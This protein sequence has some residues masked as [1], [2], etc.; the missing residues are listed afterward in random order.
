MSE[1]NSKNKPGVKT[2]NPEYPDLTTDFTDPYNDNNQ[3]RGKDN[4]VGWYRSLGDGAVGRVD[5]GTTNTFPN[6]AKTGSNGQTLSAGVLGSAVYYEQS[7]YGAA[8]NYKAHYQSPFDEPGAAVPADQW[9]NS[10]NQQVTPY[11][12]TNMANGA[13]PFSGSKAEKNYFRIS[14]VS[15]WDQGASSDAADNTFTVAVWVRSNDYTHLEASQAYLPIITRVKENSSFSGTNA[16]WRL[17]FWRS[18]TSG[19]SGGYGTIYAQMWGGGSAY[20]EVNSACFGRETYGFPQTSDPQ[21]TPANGTWIQIVMTFDGSNGDSGTYFPEANS[22]DSLKIY[23]NGKHATWYNATGG[24]FDGQLNNATAAPIWVNHGAATSVPGGATWYANSDVAEFAFWNK[25]LSPR[26]IKALYNG[27]VQGIKKYDSGL[28]KNPAR[29]QLQKLDDTAGNA[30]PTTAGSAD[31][32]RLGKRTPRFDD[33]LTRVFTQSNGTVNMGARLRSDDKLLSASFSTPNKPPTLAVNVAADDGKSGR[34]DARIMGN[35]PFLTASVTQFKDT[36]KPFD[37]SKYYIDNNLPFYVSSSNR[38][39]GFNSRVDNKVLIEIDTNPSQDSAFGICQQPYGRPGYANMTAP[40]GLYVEGGADPGPGNALMNPGTDYGNEAWFMGYWNNDLK[41][42]E[43]IGRGFCSDWSI[44]TM[45]PYWYSMFGAAHSLDANDGLV[46]R[47]ALSRNID[48]ACIGFPAMNQY[49]F[50]SSSPDPSGIAVTD[51]I[52]N[53]RSPKAQFHNTGRPITNFGFPFHGRYEATGSQLIKMSDY[54]DRPFLLEKIII[55][56][57]GTHDFPASGYRANQDIWRDSAIAQNGNG[58]EPTLPTFHNATSF[59]ILKQRSDRFVISGSGRWPARL[60][61]NNEGDDLGKQSGKPEDPVPNF[62]QTSISV[63]GGPPYQASTGQGSITCFLTGAIPGKA[64]TNP[65]NNW[66]DNPQSNKTLATT[67]RDLVTYAQHVIYGFVGNPANSW[68]RVLTGSYNNG[69]G[70]PMDPHELIAAGMGRDL[71]TYVPEVDNATTYLPDNRAPGPQWSNKTMKPFGFTAA[72]QLTG[73]YILTA[74]CRSSIKPPWAGSLS[75]WSDGV[76]AYQSQT[77]LDNLVGGR[78]NPAGQ[79]GDR[80]PLIAGLPSGKDSDEPITVPSRSYLRGT[81]RPAGYLTGSTLQSIKDADSSPYLLMPGDNIILGVQAPFARDVV[82][83]WC[84]GQAPAEDA[85]D[86]SL[87]GWRADEGFSVGI[88]PGAGKFILIGSYVK[89]HRQNNESLNQQTTTPGVHGIVSG[90]PIVDQWEIDSKMSYSGSYLDNA[91]TGSMT[92]PMAGWPRSPAATVRSHW[93][94]ASS[95]ASGSEGLKNG[96]W[97]GYLKPWVAR[98]SS[99][100]VVASEASDDVSYSQC[101]EPSSTREITATSFGGNTGDVFGFQRNVRLHCFGETYYDSLVPDPAVCWVADNQPKAYAGAEIQ[102]VLGSGETPTLGIGASNS[103]N[104]AGVSLADGTGTGP[105]NYGG[106]T[107]YTNEW[108]LPSF[109]FEARYRGFT[110]PP[111]DEFKRITEHNN[112]RVR[113]C[114]P[115]FESST[116]DWNGF[117]PTGDSSPNCPQSSNVAGIPTLYI[118]G[119]KPGP[120]RATA[121]SG[122]L[123]ANPIANTSDMNSLFET[124]MPVLFGFGTGISGSVSP[125]AR[126]VATDVGNGYSPTG[127]LN[128]YTSDGSG[129]SSALGQ[130]Q[131]LSNKP[132][133]CKYGL[134]SWK[135]RNTSVIFRSSRFGQYRDILEQRRYSRFY[136]ARDAAVELSAPVLCQFREPLWLDPL[137]DVEKSPVNTQCSNIST[138]ATASVPYFDGEVK[139]RGPLIADGSDTIVIE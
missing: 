134:Y 108:W 136:I 125:Y 73:S 11:L 26:E 93:A 120:Q 123:M 40:G 14:D 78:M 72:N 24:G 7:S 18:A 30:Y 38:M 69:A 80:R 98:D 105:Y 86:Y 28:V 64:F 117:S 6:M 34:V 87:G 119:L 74:S 27:S 8:V 104:Q 48:Q 60:T 13:L 36:F 59:F 94:A 118:D 21:T 17:Q 137:S 10:F 122:D 89:N 111:T 99:G 4:L 68:S 76:S 55:V 132:R 95:M 22:S 75:V 129:G 12:P 52:T 124:V 57:S 100:N 23:V 90:G 113:L 49:I 126:M 20:H 77:Q 107:R 35:L 121:A 65:S 114:A 96:P 135:P 79:L 133:G 115:V 50:S 70:F 110:E 84:G 62:K 92:N 16:V 138:F 103:G 112:Y 83:S 2:R 5:G 1:W 45:S 131:Y 101:V 61:V 37:D 54:I 106:A 88:H 31:Q 47:S 128:P 3:Y 97:D 139:N 39:P 58:T 130:Y 91:I 46:G 71:N 19:D 66:W 41:R 56:Y 32:Y 67:T 43:R 25:V 33:T 9:S 116:E 15:S 82:N 53:L 44:A 81:Y 102:D 63:F 42:W 85:I 109:P 29:P 127:S 51:T